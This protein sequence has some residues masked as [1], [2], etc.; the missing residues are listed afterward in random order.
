MSADATPTANP[1][2]Q[3]WE[4]PFEA[5]PFAAIAP[6]QMEEAFEAGLAAHEAEIAAIRDASE[7]ASFENTILALERAGRDL[8]RVAMVF[9]NLAGAHT[10]PEIQAIERRLA[11]KLA[12]HSSKVS[13]D[14]GLFARV[15]AVFAAREGLGLDAEALRLLERTHL[16]FVRAGAQLAP[17]AKERLA[18]IDQR[19]AEIGTAFAQN[20]LGDESGFT[21]VLEGEDDLA[22]LP[23][24]L[25]SAAAR[26]AQD[27]GLSGKHVITL[28]R[29]SVEPFLA[30][31]A[32]RDLR[33]AAFEA[34]TRRG[35]NG[36]E[37]DNRGI[38]AETVRLRAERA[39]LL[40]YES[41]AHYKLDD[42]MAKTPDAVSGLLGRVWGPAR[43]RAGE[44]RDALAALAAENGESAEIAPWDWRY[45]A[46]GVRRARY[47]LDEG[48]I[49][50]YLSLDRM[51]EAAF[52]VAS[53]LFGLVFEERTDVPTWHPDVRAFEVK[54]AESAHVGL[55][56]GDY[57]ARPS[58][59]SGAWASAFR[60]QQNLD[61]RVR[62]IIVN[63]MN[64]SAGSP[65]APPLLS[66]DD[67]RTL[68]HEFGHALHG[69]LSEV[70]Y[71]SLAGT[72][73]A[74]D[75]VELPSQLYEHWLET[76]E[77][78]ERFARHWKTNE[79]MPQALREKLIGARTFNQGFATV[80]YLACAFVDL[81]FH[82]LPS[83]GN[84][85]PEAFERDALERIGMPDEI[86]MRHRTP[87]FAHVFAG[88][89]Y[90]AGYYSYMWSEVLDADAFEAFRETGDVF[91]PD[92]AAKLKEHIYSAGNRRDPAEAYAAFRGRMPDVG[93]LLAKRGLI[94]GME[95][96]AA[97]EA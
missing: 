8:R 51:I 31:S 67:A 40:G 33:K 53:R 93:P 54:D 19:L 68:F 9:Y 89:G 75:F 55:F 70:T 37:R 15:D 22:G 76:P 52:H 12:R 94:E 87:H 96:P 39:R 64:F 71:P 92:T 73:V 7:P 27:R 50:P 84:I 60:T 17:A 24:W 20:V 72:A 5:P 86:V 56:Y 49:K 10:N 59:R 14:A 25:V 26:A 62:P 77:I 16:G 80:E 42:A 2:F 58:K 1:F 38:V 36:G 35:A 45:L 4:T 44:E 74:R 88:S 66:F 48:A 23:D 30:F 6:A 97:G 63:V 69:L 95:A 41:F 46:E 47:D 29:S 81:D 32:R 3:A 90:A 18:E 13:L 28:A 57:F 85:D 82:L 78:L 83:A 43:A 21:L 79:P 61:G 65:D 11:P 91:H 34:W